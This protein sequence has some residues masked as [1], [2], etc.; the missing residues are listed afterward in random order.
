MDASVIAKWFLPEAGSEAALAL[1]RDAPLLV[2]SLLWA[3]VG[4]ILWKGCRKQWLT[5]DAAR[6]ALHFL[7]RPGLLE[8]VPTESLAPA[9]F[10]LSLDLDHP[11]YD[12]LYLALAEREGV[13]LVTADR[14]FLE[15]ARA[16]GH[17]RVVAL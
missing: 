5:A 4:N 10:A 13:P 16:A 2:P 15:R 11:L 3:E 7:D 1:R 9:A 8:A 14:R 12:C 6:R 17:H